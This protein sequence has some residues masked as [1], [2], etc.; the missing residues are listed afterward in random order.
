MVSNQVMGPIPPGTCS[1]T[2]AAST[3]FST[4]PGDQ[5]FTICPPTPVR[6]E[7]WGTLKTLYR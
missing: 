6:Q 2:P 5:F 4:L 7:S 1:L 3:D